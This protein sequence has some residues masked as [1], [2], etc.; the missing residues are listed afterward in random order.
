MVTSLKLASEVFPAA[1]GLR[2]FT[3]VQHLRNLQQADRRLITFKGHGS[4]AAH[5]TPGDAARLLLAVAGSDLVKDSLASLQ[6]FGQLLP[7]GRA[8]DR[9]RITLEDHFA[10][11][12]A[13]VAAEAYGQDAP[14]DGPD[15]IA[16]SLISVAGEG[17]SH[18]RAAISYLVSRGAAPLGFAPADWRAPLASVADY[19]AGVKGAGIIRER[20]LTRRSI[21]QIARSL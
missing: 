9:S 10:G 3:V 15:T 7:V 1:L 21:E 12:L 14:D 18:P 2:T 13:T 6:G 5:M 19:V 8:R 11:F 20:H 16:L 17:A 4:S